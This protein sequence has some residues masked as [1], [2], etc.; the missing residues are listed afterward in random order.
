[1]RRLQILRISIVLLGLYMTLPV[2][3]FDFSSAAVPFDE[4]NHNGRPVAIGPRPRFWVPGA[5]HDFDVP[6]GFGYHT[7][8]WPFRVWKPLYLIYLRFYG[9]ERPSEWR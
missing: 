1:M 3:I 8:A 2:V 4:E 6:G 5:A 9:Y 7:S